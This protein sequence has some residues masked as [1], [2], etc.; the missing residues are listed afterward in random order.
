M[1]TYQTHRWAQPPTEMLQEL[2]WRSLRASGRYSAV[3]ILTS[4]SRGDFLLEGKL[5]D[6]TEISG[7]PLGARLSLGLEL[8]DMKTGAIVWTHSYAHDDPVNGKD[9]SAV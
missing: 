1:G 4:G 8:H 5:S 9:V 7:R 2:L 6:F 3:N